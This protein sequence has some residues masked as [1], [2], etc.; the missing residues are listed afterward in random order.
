MSIMKQSG[1]TKEE[2]ENCLRNKQLYDK[3]VAARELATNMGVKSTPT[4]LIS[5]KLYRGVL[6]M[7]DLDRIIEPL[8]KN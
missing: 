4:F 1:M 6:S 7:R 8:L 2:F 3:I 5:G